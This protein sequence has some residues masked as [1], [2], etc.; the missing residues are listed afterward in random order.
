MAFSYHIN[1]CLGYDQTLARHLPLNIESNDLFT[2]TGDGLILCKLINAA[3]GDTIDERAINKKDGM[4]IYHKTENL[5]LALNAARSIGCQVINIGAQD[6][7]DAKPILILGLIW[8]IIRIQLFHS[9]TLKNHPELVVL[10][11]ENETL[12]S[13]IKLPPE[14]ILLRWVNYH[15][16]KAGSSKRIKNFGNDIQDSQVY[17]ILTNQLNPS[18]C[19]LATETDGLARAAHVIRNA[20][21]LGAQI[22][23]QPRD[24]V[25]GNKKLNVSFVA[26]IFNV[27]PGL[28]L[29]EEEKVNIDFSSINLLDDDNSADSR[30]ERVFRMWMNSLNIENTY[31]N[32]LFSDVEDGV[33]L[34][35]VIEIVQPNLI[36][37]KKVSLDS[38]SKYKKI[39]NCNQAVEVCKNE[40]KFSLVG[41]GGIDIVNGNKKL[42][43]AIVWQLLR[44]YTLSLLS[45]LAASQGVSEVSEDKIVE[46]ANR[47]VAS[48]GKRSSMRNFKDA[49]L[50]SSLFFLDL[51]SAIEPRAVNSELITPGRNPDEQLL[52]AKYA[53]SVSRKIGAAVFLIPEDIV[54]LKSKML[55]TFCASLWMTELLQNN[56]VPR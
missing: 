30:E 45:N 46:W 21:N 52:N 43:L 36:N 31:V 2:K 8:Q 38:A 29:S 16:T 17:S 42:I 4:N 56:V 9:I 20:K 33:V 1:Q 5:N 55:F 32:S 27:C 49:S 25:D 48:S 41:V 47:K 3:V 6:F 39:E 51:I 18:Q 40:L 44:R 26:Q 50:K 28:S 35:K 22:F 37:W 11:E 53:I 19:S 13:F 14:M 15:L 7:I 12:A 24:I 34:L 10:L 23:I 54:E